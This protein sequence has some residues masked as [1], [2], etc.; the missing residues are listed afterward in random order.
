MPSVTYH[1]GPRNPVAVEADLCRLWRENLGVTVGPAQKFQRLY[2][3][4]PEPADT[5][6]VLEAIEGDHARIVGANGMLP[7]GFWV[8]GQEVRAVVSC[9]LAVDHAHRALLPALYLVRAFR[10]EVAARFDMAYGFPNGKAEGVLKRAGFK[11]LGRARRWARVLRHA[12]YVAGGSSRRDVP[13]LVRVAA[14]HPWVARA[15]AAAL[16]AV[17]LVSCSVRAARVRWSHEVQTLAAPDDRW[18]ALWR[19]VRD[20]YGV[21][22]VRTA[23]FLRW[24]FPADS[25]TRF[26]ALQR[27]GD[28]GLRAYAV[29]QLDA[30]TGAAHVR[31]LFGH[32]DD[33]GRLVDV[34]AQLAYR[35]GASSLSVRF[36]GAPK[37]EQLLVERGFSLREGSR[38]V[39]LDVVQAHSD[40]GPVVTDASRWHLFDVDED[41]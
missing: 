13:R 35:A 16:D 5:V 24:R 33:L 9:D 37:V 36:L 12:R 15:G 11:E 28:P 14:S 1:A 25:E 10:Q 6:V 38:S 22:G 40:L 17:R 2:R 34:L 41:G 4:A 21:V 18:D 7:R 31:D 26:V 23:H 19:D 3:D 20:E 39:V 32:H 30:A 29:L 8:A 27:R